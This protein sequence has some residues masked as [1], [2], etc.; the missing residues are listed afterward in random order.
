[1][2]SVDARLEKM[3]KFTN[4]CAKAHNTTKQIIQ[5]LCLGWPAALGCLGHTEPCNTDW[6]HLQ[7]QDSNWNLTETYSS[8]LIDRTAENK[9][10]CLLHK[11]NFRGF[12]FSV[13]STVC[14][15]CVFNQCFKS[16]YSFSVLE[17]EL[18]K[19]IESE[20]TLTLVLGPL[21][22]LYLMM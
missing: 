12:F 5:I 18:I 7:I 1:M 6:S 22:I 3:T 16:F 11:N 9:T 17:I 4:E 10:S 19:H 21:E 13:F 2:P 20:L 14:Q 8:H 15:N